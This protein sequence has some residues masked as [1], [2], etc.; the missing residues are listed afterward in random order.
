MSLVPVVDLFAGPG[1]LGEG[2]SALDEGRRFDIALSVEMDPTARAT[3][4]LRAFFRTF[5]NGEAPPEYYAYI[6]GEITRAALAEAHPDAWDHAEREA[7]CAQL[8]QEPARTV[9]ARVAEALGEAANDGHFVL[10]GG[11]PCQAYSLVG[12]SRMRGARDDFDADHRHLLY[13]EYL[14][15]LADHAPAVF[16]LENVKG[17]LS[18]THKGEQIFDRILSDLRRP[19]VALSDRGSRARALEYE[20]FPLGYPAQ[21]GLPGTEPNPADFVLK[22]EE[23]GLPQARHRVIILGVRRDLASHAR[24]VLRPLA[25]TGSHPTSVSEA[26]GDLPALR[27]GLS[28]TPDSDTEWLKCVREAAARLV[29]QRGISREMRADLSHV[30]SA[31]SIPI[32]GRGADYIPGRNPKPRYRSDWYVDPR[33]RGVLN[34]QTRGHIPLDLARYLF[35]AVFARAEGRSPQL[36]AFPAELL[37]RHQNVSRALNGNL[38]SDR[39]RVQVR[40]RPSTTITSHI[41][42]DGHYF[43]HPDPLQCRSLTVREAARLQTFPDNYFFEGPRTKQYLQVGNAVPPLLANQIAERVAAILAPMP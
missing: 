1:G 15:I 3:L 23:L 16:V 33:L 5:P 9:K 40:D 27:S 31:V 39:F 10:V 18:S 8:G 22:A 14:R 30:Q 42:K 43:I 19:G 29:K 37:P 17:L 35:S 2:F 26:I 20:L 13:R 32:A 21:P 4:M 25:A 6:R 38:F 28:R 12:R 34:H 24:T 41:S 36:G 11:P 7:W